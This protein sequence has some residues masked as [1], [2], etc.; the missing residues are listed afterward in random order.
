MSS[1]SFVAVFVYF[2]PPSGA[3]TWQ[4]SILEMWILL[5]FSSRQVFVQDYI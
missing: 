1:L 4:Q 2:V 3:V 5:T